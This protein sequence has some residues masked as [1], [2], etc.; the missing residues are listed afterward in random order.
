MPTYIMLS[1]LT[2]EGRRT[3]RKNP[4]RIKEVNEEIERM[5]AKVIAQYATL[6]QYD[7]VNILEAPDND[8]IARISIDLGARG[9]VQFITL[10][11]IPVVEFIKKMG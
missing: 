5:G 4:D 1:T 6:G 2:N 8:A 11:A 7:F 3:V 9:T 10:P